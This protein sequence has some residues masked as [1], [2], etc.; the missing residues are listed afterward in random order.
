MIAFLVCGLSLVCTILLHWCSAILL[1]GKSAVERFFYA[2]FTGLL[3]CAIA[4]WSLFDLLTSAAVLAWFA[5]WS[6]FYLFLFTLS[7]G[8]ISVKILHTLYN[9]PRDKQEIA[10]LY[11]PHGMVDVRFNRLQGSGLIEPCGAIR[12]TPKGIKVARVAL[13][14]R[15]LLHS[16]KSHG[17]VR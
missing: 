5:F 12:L 9:R 15:S 10:T 3:G 16:S 11:S 7:L 1:P 4:C 8:S 17:D 2:F 14:A 6:E 13:Y